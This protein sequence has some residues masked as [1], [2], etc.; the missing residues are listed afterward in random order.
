ML[1]CAGVGK[2]EQLDSG[3]GPDKRRDRIET[4]QT[5]KNTHEKNA[6][7]LPFLCFLL[8]RIIKLN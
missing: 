6:Y 5:L 1:A 4:Q 3:L 2:E 7:Y 8:L